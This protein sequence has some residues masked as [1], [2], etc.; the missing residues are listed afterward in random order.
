MANI[1]FTHSYFYKFDTKQWN[2]KQPF[3]P[4]GTIT[5]AAYLREK[6]HTVN[7]FDTNLAN[8]PGQI[9]TSIDKIK[10]SYLVIY[11]D[12]FNYLTKMCL[13]LMRDAAFELIR[14]GKENNCT[15]IVSSS[16]STDHFSEYLENGADCILLG[17]G[18]ESLYKILDYLEGKNGEL[19]AING[20]V[21]K[22]NGKFI[23]TGRRGVIDN[24]DD[25][26]MAAWDLVNMEDYKSIW[27]ENHGYFS[28]NIATTRGCPYSCNWCA[29]PIFGQKYHARS[30]KS[31]L[32]EM[33]FL[34]NNYGTSYFWICDDIFGLMPGWI[35]EFRDMVKTRKLNFKYH[36]QSRVD[37][38]LRDDT[39]EAMAESGLDIVWVGAESGSQKILDAMEKDVTVDQ[40][41]KARQKLKKSGVRVAFFLQFGYLGETMDDI[42]LTE[43]MLFDLMPDDMGI[44][45][46]YPLPGTKFYE[47]VK[48]DL[49]QKANW[50]DSDDLA[51]MFKNT[52]PPRFY[53]MLHRYIHK[54]FRKKQN[55]LK[56][57]HFLKSPVKNNKGIIRSVIVTVYYIPMTIFYKMSMLMSKSQRS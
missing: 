42:K 57:L 41:Y 29:K 23:N 40:I 54:K 13:T 27:M 46:S 50:S 39:I 26:P 34:I 16:D 45:V 19:D 48:D 17:E 8:D 51:L 30:P 28:L 4:L 21:Y 10:P 36:M 18:E 11:D 9:Q 37:V 32:D 25:L 5:A 33:E 44:S 31:V 55:I 52:Y 38:M 7:L 2:N 43:K 3:P 14:I 35:Q 24:L 12:G 56:I 15:V 20:I 49:D 47:L 6:G 1:L 53:K 22:Q